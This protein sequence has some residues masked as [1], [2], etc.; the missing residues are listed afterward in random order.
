M[1]VTWQIGIDS[2]DA[3]QLLRSIEELSGNW[4]HE[5]VDAVVEVAFSALGL[6]VEEEDSS[7]PDLDG[8][9]EEFTGFE[10]DGLENV[11]GHH[12]AHRTEERAPELCALNIFNKGAEGQRFNSRDRL[13]EV[14]VIGYRI[15]GL[16]TFLRG[17]AEVAT[18]FLSG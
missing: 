1:L 3:A 17:S 6:S 15:S 5:G 9:K 14:P 13:I 8:M 10:H 18:A 4:V 12:P 16:P 2:H 11:I 7:G